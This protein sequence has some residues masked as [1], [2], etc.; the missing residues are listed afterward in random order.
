VTETTQGGPILK[1]PDGLRFAAGPDVWSLQPLQV[2]P[3][4]WIAL[5]PD[6]PELVYSPAGALSWIL[7]TMQEPDM[8]TVEVLGH[9]VYRLDYAIRQRLRAR[10]GYV[11]N[12]GGLLSARTVRENI[13]LPVSVHGH[14]NATEEDALVDAMLERLALV[15]VADL[16]P[17]EMDGA[18]RWRACLARSL[19]LGP[20]WLI[21]EGIGNWEMDRGRGRGWQYLQQCK[22]DGNLAA[23]ICLARPNPEFETWFEDHQGVI[24]RYKK[25]LDPNQGM[26]AQ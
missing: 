16:Q 13:A 19:M 15:K 21:L 17:H 11:H 5:V 18:T 2:P 3:G 22:K 7:A 9:D 8:G 26:I 10:I 6:D 12:Y 20:E 14:L 4:S 1:L 23:G 24:L 25:V